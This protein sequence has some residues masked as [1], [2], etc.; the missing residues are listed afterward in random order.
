MS[1][2][3]RSIGL[4]IRGDDPEATNDSFRLRVAHAMVNEDQTHLRDFV[5][6]DVERVKSLL[7]QLDRGLLSD[8]SDSIGSSKSAEGKVGVSIPA[9]LDIGGAGHYVSTDQSIETRTLHDFVYSQTEEKL[10]ELGCIKLLPNDVT[11]DRLRSS[12]VRAALSP[13]EY[14]LVRGKIELSDYQYMMSIL[15]NFNEIWRIIT[16]FSYQERLQAAEGKDRGEV[17]K[18]LQRAVAANKLDDKYVKNVMKILDTF[19]KD[20]LIIKALPFNTDPNIRIVGPLQ[21]DLLRDRLD[22]IRFKFGSSPAADWTVFRSN[23]QRFPK[24]TNRG[25]IALSHSPMTLSGRCTK[26]SMPCGAL[27]TS[28]GLDTPR[29]LLPRLLSIETKPPHPRKLVAPT[30]VLTGGRRFEGGLSTIKTLP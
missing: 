8:R 6:L 11:S 24:S 14:V 12:D 2:T 22:D 19:V 4:S 9:L 1:S 17:N 16:E 21:R 28:L 23:L 3:S 29:S 5:Y 10:L 25:P 26:S 18:E 30:G 15:S 27:K 13:V 7:A 20:R